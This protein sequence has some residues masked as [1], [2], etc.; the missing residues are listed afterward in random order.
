VGNIIVWPEVAT[1]AILAAQ[2][3]VLFVAAV[4]ALFQAREARRLRLEQQRPFVVIDVDFVGA[5]TLEAG[6]S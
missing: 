3:L 1:V 2:L 4:V 5:P 6:V